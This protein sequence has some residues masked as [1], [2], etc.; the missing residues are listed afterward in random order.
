MQKNTHS[1]YIRKFYSSYITTTISITLVLFVV[2]LVGV[3][4]FNAKRL[5]DYAKENVGF[6][7]FIAE[8]QRDADILRLQKELDKA[9]Y[10]R[11]TRLV[12]KEEAAAILEKDLGEDF[13]QFM[14]A[15]PLQTSL[16]VKLHADYANLDSIAIIEKELYKSELIEDLYYQKSLIDLVNKNVRKIS[17]LLFIVA[18]VL[19][20]ISMILINNTIRLAIYAKRFLIYTM[21]L[22]GATEGFIRKP[23]VLQTALSAFI[24]TLLAIGLLISMSLMLQNELDELISFQ[25]IGYVFAIMLFLGI[26]MTAFATFFAVRRYLF[27]SANELYGG[28]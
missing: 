27:H 18:L 25:D 6:T 8:N 15:N 23:F 17:I 24:A 1:F 12:S 3:L 11:E 9:D 14:G 20:L 13:V 21:Q 2:G 7:V 22:V 19:L 28:L 5:A 4:L 10:V 26:S 16:E